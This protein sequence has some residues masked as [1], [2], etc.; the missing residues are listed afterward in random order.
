MTD[1]VK[2]DEEKRDERS[3]WLLKPIRTW[4]NVIQYGIILVVVILLTLIIL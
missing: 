1:S 2:N 4:E 3:A